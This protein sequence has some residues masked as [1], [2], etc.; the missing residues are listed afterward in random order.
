MIIYQKYYWLNIFRKASIHPCNIANEVFGQKYGVFDFLHIA[1]RQ[2][3]SRRNAQSWHNTDESLFFYF[4]FLYIFLFYKLTRQDFKET[5]Q[6]ERR[7]K[8]L[9]DK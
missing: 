9:K 4:S 2:P 5:I 8:K 6:R 3:P 7:N 1:Q